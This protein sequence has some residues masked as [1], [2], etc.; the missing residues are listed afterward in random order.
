[1]NTPS[2]SEQL[3]YFRQQQATI[4]DTI[5]QLVTLGLCVALI[6]RPR[7]SRAHAA[8]LAAAT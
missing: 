4:L 1:M 2:P 7:W 5:E 8:R 3:R 6:L